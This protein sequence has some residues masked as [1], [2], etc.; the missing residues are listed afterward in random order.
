MARQL[1]AAA[2]RRLLHLRELLL[3]EHL[4]IDRHEM[5]RRKAGARHRVGERLADVREEHGRAVDRDDLLQML[6]GHAA[7]REESRL[8]RLDQEQRLVADLRRQRHRQHAFV[9]VGL[10]LLAARAKADFDLRLL[11]VQERL[12]RA[13]VLEREVLEVDLV[14]A[15]RGALGAVA[16]VVAGRP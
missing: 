15:E 5:D 4:E 10:D 3:V 9:D 6:G 13:G 1:T 2:R 16:A 7:D 8:R 14:D 12:R 11:L